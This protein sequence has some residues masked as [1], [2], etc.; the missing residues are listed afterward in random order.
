MPKAT[1]STETTRHNLVTL[2]G[3]FVDLRRLSFGE[4]QA[5]TDM[6]MKMAFQGGGG[7]AA[8]AVA[9]MSAAEVAFFE[10]SRCIVDHNLSRDEDETDLLNFTKRADFEQLDPRVGDEIDQQISVMN[11]FDVTELGNGS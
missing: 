5:R 3:G 4:K 10:F 9:E 6:A 7:E 1:V 2:P 11:N 8:S